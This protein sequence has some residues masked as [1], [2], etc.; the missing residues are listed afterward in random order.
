[1]TATRLW[2]LAAPGPQDCQGSKDLRDQRVT[3]EKWAPRDQQGSSR[4][5]SSA[6]ELR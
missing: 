5:T 4:L 2:S 1:M 6:W 3:K